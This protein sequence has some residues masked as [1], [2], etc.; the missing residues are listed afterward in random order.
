MNLVWA[1]PITAALVAWQRS[2]HVID[3]ALSAVGAEMGLPCD[4]AGVPVHS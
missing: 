3:D 2:L 1:I 4:A